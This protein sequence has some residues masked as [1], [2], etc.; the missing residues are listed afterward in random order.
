MCRPGV[1][2]VMLPL[3]LVPVCSCVFL[4]ASLEQGSVI[5]IAIICLLSNFPFIA[6][7]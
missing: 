3:S 4:S 7:E 5:S 6:I 1:Y 2:E